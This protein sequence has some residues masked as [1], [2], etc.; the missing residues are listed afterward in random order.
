M[1]D[2]V[3]SMTAPTS[4]SAILTPFHR[5]GALFHTPGQAAT[6]PSAGIERQAPTQ[7]AQGAAG[8]LPAN[9]RDVLC[10]RGG[11]G[12]KAGG[13]RRLAQ[14]VDGS[15]VGVRGEQPPALGEIDAPEPERQV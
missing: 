13:V 2:T 9:G 6:I 5:P 15:A 10:A 14:V 3:P 7:K 4:S 8:P 12:P 1:R 11:E